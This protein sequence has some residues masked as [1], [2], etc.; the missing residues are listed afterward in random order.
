MEFSRG[1]RRKSRHTPVSC[2]TRLCDIAPEYL[3]ANLTP[4][5]HRFAVVEHA[6]RRR[7][8]LAGRNVIDLP[9]LHRWTLS[10]RRGLLHYVVQ[11]RLRQLV[12]L[13][14]LWFGDAI[15]IPL[16]LL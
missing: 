12:V 1:R 7:T 5:L 13:R 9:L 16:S 4:E 3:L 8:L 2:F 15:P 11:D 14:A 6:F 10:G